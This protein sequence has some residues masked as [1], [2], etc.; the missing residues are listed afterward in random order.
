M[1][2]ANRPDFPLTQGGMLLY[3]LLCGGDY[4]HGLAGCG[5]T[6][7]VA[8]ARC[9]F[10]DQLLDAYRS[11][12]SAD[13]ERFLRKWRPAVQS[14]LLT[15]SQQFLSR[16]QFDIA[17]EISHEFPDRRTLQYYANPVTSW[18]PGRIPPDP[19]Q[20]EF[21][22]PSILLITNFCKE[23]FHWKPQAMKKIFKAQLWEGIFLQ[24]LYS[25]R[26]SQHFPLLFL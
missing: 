1:Y 24:M 15:N 22:Q 3:A 18:S 6:T 23:Y 16:R 8:L 19:S 2:S 9:G 14:E 17:G 5:P 20:W 12:Q 25:V 10:G 26:Y 21:T 4:D 13:F 7:S 11:H